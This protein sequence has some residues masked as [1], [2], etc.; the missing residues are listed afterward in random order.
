MTQKCSSRLLVGPNVWVFGASVLFRMT[1]AAVHGGPRPRRR[2]CRCCLP[3]CLSAA[4]L[5]NN[6][7]N[8]RRTS[9]RRLYGWQNTQQNLT[10]RPYSS[11]YINNRFPEV[12]FFSFHL[13]AHHISE[14]EEIYE[15]HFFPRITTVDET[16]R[17]RMAGFW[18]RYGK[19]GFWRRYGK[20]G[21]WRRNSDS[22]IS[23]L[24]TVIIVAW[25]ELF[26]S[27]SR[28]YHWLGTLGIPSP[29][30]SYTKPFVYGTFWIPIIIFLHEFVT[31]FL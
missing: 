8:N 30:S 3:V 24:F 9:L 16:W 26:F 31:R 6:N 7:N 29:V 27:C 4:V 5:G 19:A 28:A 20:T 13:Q 21:F 25:V 22:L 14:H 18:R 12:F 2:K 15:D 10:P 17:Y 1:A 23:E 11:Y